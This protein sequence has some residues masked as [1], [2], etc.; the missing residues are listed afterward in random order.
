MT[1]T[2][3]AV[4]RVVKD[5]EIRETSKGNVLKFRMAVDGYNGGKVTDFYNVSVWRSIDFLAPQLTRG[6]F[7]VAVGALTQ[8]EYEYQGEKRRD[9]EINADR[10]D[11]APRNA[12]VDDDRRAASAGP[13]Q[14][15]GRQAASGSAAVA[16]IDDDIP[17]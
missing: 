2:V 4:G 9:L 17:F 15:T 12:A 8:R 10:V 11:A 5:A 16:D 6:A 3:T 14:Q 13:T 7:V 1:A